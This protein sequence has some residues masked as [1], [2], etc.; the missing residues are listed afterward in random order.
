MGGPREI[1]NHEPEIDAMEKDK[2]DTS[3]VPNVDASR[4]EPLEAHDLE[5]V[6][7]ERPNWRDRLQERDG[8]ESTRARDHGHDGWGR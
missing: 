1:S 6:D 3:R 4:W 2:D 8:W 5:G 7:L